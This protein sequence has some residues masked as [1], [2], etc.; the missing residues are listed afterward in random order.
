M[1]SR[2]L[3]SEIRVVA[4]CLEAA[5]VATGDVGH[6]VTAPSSFRAPVFTFD[7]G[8]TVDLA[9]ILRALR[10]AK[11]F[12]AFAPAGGATVYAD[13]RPM[14]VRAEVA[15]LVGLAFCKLLR[16]ALTHA[17]PCGDSGHIGIHLWPVSTLPGAR[18]FL[19]IADD[20]QG[21]NNEPP[22]TAGSGI[23]TARHCVERC[24]GVLAREP[25]SGTVWRIRLPRE[26]GS[27]LGGSQY[28]DRASPE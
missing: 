28:P 5:A 10:S 20:G 17:F 22:A 18:A 9:R 3:A 23:P 11:H 16:N 6:G 7:P 19:L 12:A 4:D 13:L 21:F 24:G 25:G 2:S 8:T 15:A 14:V 27:P 1:R 26:T